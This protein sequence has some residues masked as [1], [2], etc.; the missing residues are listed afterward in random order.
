M[1]FILLAFIL[2]TQGFTVLCAQS[3]ADSIRQSNGKKKTP[4]VETGVASYYHRKFQGRLTASGEKYDTLKMTAAHNALP[5]GTKIKVTNLKNGKS[6]VVT[7]NDR[8]HHRNTRLV[9]LSLAAARKLGYTGR[10]LTRVR[11]EIQ[12][13]KG[14]DRQ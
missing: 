6:V 10:G 2:L 4:D 13:R 11:V 8:L 5:F 7:V 14:N 3:A 9:D 1:K 12:K